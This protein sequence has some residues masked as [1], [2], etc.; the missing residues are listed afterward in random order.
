MVYVYFLAAG[1]AVFLSFLVLVLKTTFDQLA[2]RLLAGFLFALAIVLFFDTGLAF[3]W[4]LEYP[5]LFGWDN[6]ALFLMPPLLYLSVQ[7]FTS[8]LPRLSSKHFLHFVPAILCMIIIVIFQ[9]AREMHEAEAM[10]T[11]QSFNSAQLDWLSLIVIFPYPAVYLFLAYRRL[12]RHRKI[13]MVLQSSPEQTDLSWLTRFLQACIVLFVVWLIAYLFQ[14]QSSSDY[15][16]LTYLAGIY[17]LG[18]QALKQSPVF[19]F[20]PHDRAEVEE[21]LSEKELQKLPVQLQPVKVEEHKQAVI[22]K[23]VNEKLY[24]KKDLSL[25]DLAQA[26]G[27]SI[28]HTSY[29][30]NQGF[31][32]NFYQLVNQYRVEESKRLLLDPALRH[33]NLIGISERAGFSSKTTFNTTFKKVTGLTPTQFMQQ[34]T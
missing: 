21:L 18:W 29:V 10:V 15:S 14:P 27:L 16:A 7:S 11:P 1:S 23:M 6:V 2:Y 31:G 4:L 12:V 8:P 24:Q 26:L 34:N 32:Q 30:I 25:P 33:L 13:T 28:H 22:N 17:Y 19:P 3:H 5:Q 20:S 9:V